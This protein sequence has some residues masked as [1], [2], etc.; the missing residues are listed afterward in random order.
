MKKRANP[1]F[2]VAA[3]KSGQGRGA[4]LLEWGQT[5]YFDLFDAFPFLSR[6]SLPIFAWSLLLT[7]EGLVSL[8]FRLNLQRTSPVEDGPEVLLN[9]KIV[10]EGDGDGLKSGGN[11]ILYVLLP[12]HRW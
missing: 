9:I 11:F 12:S 6:P 3:S 4:N 5:D 8:F 2:T 1:R 10:L 7:P